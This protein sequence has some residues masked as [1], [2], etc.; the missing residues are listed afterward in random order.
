[1]DTPGP[2]RSDD[3]TLR[4]SQL[5]R[6]APR[7]TPS[8]SREPVG[9]EHCEG[10]NDADH[11]KAGDWS[12]EE[13]RITWDPYGPPLSRRWEP[14]GGSPAVFLPV[15]VSLPGRRDSTGDSVAELDLL[16]PG[17]WA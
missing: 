4:G 9:T 5:T 11:P 16:V 13:V 8:G 6:G 3:L 15:Q 7:T 14:G 2:R 12:R 1:M 10:P 17:T